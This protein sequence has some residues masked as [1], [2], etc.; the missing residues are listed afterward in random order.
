MNIILKQFHELTT[1]ELYEIL[2][3]RVE[4]FVVEQNCPYEEV[5]GKDKEAYHL[6]IKEADE[7]VAYLRIL[8]AGVSHE[9]TALGRIIAKKRRSGLGSLLVKEALK[10]CKEEL[11]ADKVYIEAQVYAGDFYKKLGFKEISDEFDLDGIPHIEMIA[12]L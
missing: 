5:D 9:Y 8:P 1:D 4:V 6:F 12:N 7:I 3:L 10:V 11:K 2:K